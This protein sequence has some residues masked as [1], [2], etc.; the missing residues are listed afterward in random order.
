MNKQTVR[1]PF[2]VTL[3]VVFVAIFTAFRYFESKQIIDSFG[4][5]N[6]MLTALILSVIPAIIIYMA[7]RYLK[8]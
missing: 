3:A 6:T 5:W 7:W 4:V 2:L 1:N 8:K